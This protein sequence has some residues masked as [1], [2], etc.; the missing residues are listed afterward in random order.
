MQPAEDRGSLAWPWSSGDGAMNSEPPSAPEAELA[1]ASTSPAEAQ[2]LEEDRA[3]ANKAVSPAARAL[4][5]RLVSIASPD[6]NETPRSG[7]ATSTL[8]AS[9]GANARP[10]IVPDQV[11]PSVVNNVSLCE[12]EKAAS[13]VTV[14][15]VEV[16]LRTTVE[17]QNTAPSRATSIATLDVL[18]AGWNDD[19]P[20]SVK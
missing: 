12:P 3:A 20:W 16:P 17:R 7:S 14:T 1:P 5:T 9:N 11:C 15:E 13:R 19:T 4:S 18:L 8:F 2:P 10:S 6:T